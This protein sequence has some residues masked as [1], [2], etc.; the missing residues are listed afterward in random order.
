M[1]VGELRV[2]VKKLIN[3]FSSE[4]QLLAVSDNADLDLVVVDFLNTAQNKFSEKDKIE[5]S[6]AIVQVSS[7]A[8]DIMNPLPIDLISINKVMFIDSNN[9]RRLFA[10]Y[11]EEGN[12][13]VID[14]NYE[15]TFLIYY[16]KRPDLLI[17]DDDVPEIDERFHSYLAYYPAGE[18]LFSTGKQSEGIVLL[19]RFDSFMRECEPNNDTGSGLINV[20]GW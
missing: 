3:S 18:W 4:G 10:D 9:R 8:G 5:S 7:D 1:N 16:H 12:N 2:L 11:N 15:G 13:I 14:S 19:N 17:S 6:F 20:T